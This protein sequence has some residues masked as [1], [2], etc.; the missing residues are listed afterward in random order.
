MNLIKRLFIPLVFCAFSTNMLAH[1]LFIETNSNG[2]L[3]YTQKITVFYAEPN[4][5][6]KE[7]V[8]DWWSNTKEFTLWLTLPDGSKKKLTVS[9]HDDHF[10]SVF[11][12]LVAGNY[13]VSIHHTVPT[14]TGKTQ[15]Q[16]N[17]SSKVT[18]GKQKEELASEQLK[19]GK[20]LFMFKSVSNNK[21]EL[22]IMLL[23]DGEALPNASVTIFAPSGWE[24]TI[25]TNEKGIVNFKPEWKGKYLFEA[26]KKEEVSGKGYSGKL[27]IITTAVNF[28]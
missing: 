9:E 28:K 7:R 27:K 14:I 2:T 18:V 22:S 11:T 4:D 12:P 26:I 16:F 3:G 15:Y 5:L 13:Y 19:L 20:E 25:E 24:R 23:Y 8:E 17:A 10:T 1:A 21:K 6:K